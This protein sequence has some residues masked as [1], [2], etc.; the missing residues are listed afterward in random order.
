ME[1]LKYHRSSRIRSHGYRSRAVDQVDHSN[2]CLQTHHRR[3]QNQI[4]PL[5]R[6]RRS[7]KKSRR[8]LLQ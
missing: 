2:R 5:R 7:L 6:H 1:N 3:C 8:L 4:R